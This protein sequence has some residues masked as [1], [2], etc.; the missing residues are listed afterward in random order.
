MNE[1]KDEGEASK[2]MRKAGRPSL[3]FSH[4]T[5]DGLT[6][7]S[8]SKPYPKESCIICQVSGGSVS[9]VVFEK[10]GKHMLELSKEIY[11]KRFFRR[12]NEITK[13]ENEVTND[14]VYHSRCWANRRTK[15]RP[16]QKKD[17][18]ISHTLSEIE[19]ISFAQTQLKDPDQPYLNINIVNEIYKEMFFENG[20]LRENIVQG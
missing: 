18:S 16:P 14:V 7:R 19:V 13:T 3:S 12:L 6:S 8:N 4:Q 15:V 5:S 2:I 9:K 20:E 10:T 11:E 17:D 1:T